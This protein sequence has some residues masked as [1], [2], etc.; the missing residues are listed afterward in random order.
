MA[1]SSSSQ[2]DLFGALSTPP[3]TFEKT[4][5][6]EIE[7]LAKRMHPKIHFGTSSWTFPGWAGICYPPK[8]TE[9]QLQREGL[10]L[11][12]RYPLF[13]TAGIDRTYYKPMS[14]AELE[15]YAAQLPSGFRCTEKVWDRLVMPVFPNHA[16]YGIHAGQR[17][18]SFLDAAV[19]HDMVHAPHVGV[20]EQH[21]ATYIIEFPPLPPAGRP[22]PEVFAKRLARFLDEA[23][24]GPRYAVEIRNR[25]LLSEEYFAVLR[26]RNVSHVY[27]YWSWMP[28]IGEQLD[29]A[30]PPGDLLVARLMIRPGMDYEDRKAQFAPFDRLQDISEEMRDDIVRLARLALE[31]DRD[32]F[33]IVNNKAEGCSPLTIADLARR[34][35]GPT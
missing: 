22:R 34:L 11:Y 8:V 1:R 30:E 17:N 4:W 6:P 2:L 28:T 21:L 9:A 18:P 3:V 14:R 19:F 29:L 24:Y 15:E 10:S 12:S 26:E 32:L 33:V 27:N 7:V 23:P 5:S 16:R 20:F 25:E 35:D 13:R 31:K